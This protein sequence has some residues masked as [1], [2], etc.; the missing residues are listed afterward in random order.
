M[1]NIAISNLRPAGADLFDSS[2]SFMNDL[3]DSELDMT[4][5]GLTP[6]VFFAGVAAGIAIT[7]LLK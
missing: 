3:T 4:K 1:A 5:G 2:E 6:A 7:Y